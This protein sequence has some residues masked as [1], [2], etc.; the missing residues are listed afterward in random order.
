MDYIKLNNK[1]STEIKGLIICKLPPVT[2]PA[3]KVLQEEIDGRDGDIITELGYKAYDKEI[4]IGLARDYNID[5]VISYFD[6]EGKITFSNEP[7]K[8]YNYKIIDQ[9]DFEKLL[10]FKRAVVK[11]HIQPFKY[12]VDDDMFI[13]KIGTNNIT[14]TTVKNEGNI[15]SKPIIEIFG[16]GTVT[17]SLNGGQLF[18]IELDAEATVDSI[19]IDGEKLEAYTGTILKNRQV[20]G[21][22]TQLKFKVGDNIISWS[23]TVTSIFIVRRNRWI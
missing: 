8:Y 12:A 14:E 19:T 22:Y 17:L 4:E 5:E 13:G 1:L 10:R 6:S 16:T 11:I 2:K 15:Y 20:T 3:K 7:D 21:D 23:G 18:T 9:I